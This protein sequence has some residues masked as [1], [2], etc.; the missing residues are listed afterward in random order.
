MND[1]EQRVPFR[2]SRRSWFTAEQKWALLL[3]YDQ[4]LDRGAKSA[5]CRRV[6]IATRTPGEWL[7]LRA[8]GRLVDPVSVEAVD[9]NPGQRRRRLDWQERQEFERLRAENQSLQIKLDQSEAAVEVLGKASA[10]LE[11]LAKSAAPQE[12]ASP[13]PPPGRPEWLSDPDT[14]RLPVIPPPNS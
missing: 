11:A 6:G 1:V 10:L 14:S 7:R 9:E 5:F 13:P 3:E 4:C 8:E 2:S 12:T